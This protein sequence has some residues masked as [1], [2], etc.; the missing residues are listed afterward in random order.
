MWLL[1]MNPVLA[2]VLTFRGGGIGAS[3]QFPPPSFLLTTSY[4]TK[5]GPSDHLLKR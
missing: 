2:D 3:S 4:P 1:L 5:H